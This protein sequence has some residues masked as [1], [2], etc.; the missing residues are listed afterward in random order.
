MRL[1]DELDAAPS[2]DL[3]ALLYASKRD[4]TDQR[5]S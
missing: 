4:Y 1:R 3:V 5:A 2:A